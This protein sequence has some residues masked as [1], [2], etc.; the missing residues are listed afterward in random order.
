MKEV[1]FAYD[2]L[3]EGKKIQAFFYQPDKE[4]CGIIQILHGLAEHIGR[5]QVFIEYF[6]ARGFIVCGENHLGHGEVEEEDRGHFG[7][8]GGWDVVMNDAAALSCFLAEN[9]PSLPIIYF[10]HSMGSFLARSVHLSGAFVPDLMILSGT[11]HQSRALV[12]SG[13]LVGKLLVKCHKT[14]TVESRLMKKMTIGGYGKKFRKEGEN[15]WISSL[16]GEVAAYENDPLCGFTPK[17]GLFTDMLDGIAFVIN[18][19]VIDHCPDKIPILLISGEDDP[20]GEMG[21]GVKRAF[22]AYSKGGFEDLSMIL[23]S[24]CRHE[25]LHDFAQN[26]ALADIEAFIRERI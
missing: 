10:G 6:T 24:G 23:Y 19:K 9:H 1:V 3:K 8:E 11:G 5:Y 4:P 2:S 18:Q 26:H 16:P 20:V 14:K 21:K 17:L 25:F 7:E 15:A 22:Y 13:Q 12:K